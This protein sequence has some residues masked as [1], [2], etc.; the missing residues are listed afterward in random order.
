M[1]MQDVY[2]C[3][4]SCEHTCVSVCVT[5]AEVESGG[6]GREGMTGKTWREEGKWFI[7]AA[8]PVI[9]EK[10]HSQQEAEGP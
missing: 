5:R 9:K 8:W 1:D 2:T 4:W 3:V 7:A 6:G 10:Q